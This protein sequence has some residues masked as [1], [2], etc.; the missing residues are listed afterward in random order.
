M[1]LQKLM[2]FYR[3]D[4]DIEY[5]TVGTSRE[6]HYTKKAS[7]NQSPIGWTWLENWIKCFTQKRKFKVFLFSYKEKLMSRL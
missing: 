6:L 7:V 3:L 5:D 2:A 4:A 1:K